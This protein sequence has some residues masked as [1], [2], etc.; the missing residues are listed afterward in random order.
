MAQPFDAAKAELSGDPVPIADQ[1]DHP[2]GRNALFSVSQNGA[3]AYAASGAGSSV[4]LTWFDRSGKPA[5]TVGAPGIINWPAISPDGIK[6][7]FDRQ[8]S[9]GGTSDLWMHDLTR[10]AE[11]RFTFGPVSNLFPVWSS[12]GS[13]VAFTSIRQEGVTIAQRATTGAAQD[14]ILDKD[15]RVK[16]PMDWSGDG[17]YIFETT[18]GD[19]TGGDVWVLPR[20]GT[21]AERKPFPYLQTEFNENSPKLSPNGQWLAYSS[22]ESKRDEVYVQTFPTKSGKWQVSINGGDRPVWSRDGKEL[23]FIGADQ[24]MMA[25]EIKGGSNF[26]R[27]APVPLFDTRI[28]SDVLFDVSKDGRFLI[29]VPADQSSS[30]PVNV[31]VNW[32]AGLKR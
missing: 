17:K 8:D 26:D 15:S 14:E 5:G 1:V 30:A 27:G 21:E 3:I 4:Q 11:S 22:N 20:Q 29:P 13:Y 32:Q 19:K 28:G 10:G 7:V 6:V 16:R 23:Y 12:D 25:V 18:P 24:K 2:A 9:L 31:I